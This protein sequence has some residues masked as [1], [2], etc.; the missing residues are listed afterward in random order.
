MSFEVTP[1]PNVLVRPTTVGPC[2]S[3]AQWSIL[4]VPR[5]L[6]NF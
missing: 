6:K 2:Q 4:F 5:V 3:R 1:L